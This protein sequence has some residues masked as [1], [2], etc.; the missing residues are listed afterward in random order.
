MAQRFIPIN[1]VFTNQVGI[2]AFRSVGQAGVIPP[3][4]GGGEQYLIGGPNITEAF[5]TNGSISAMDVSY[6][7]NPLSRRT[8]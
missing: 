6:T 4:P 1:F 2:F 7:L 8:V 5:V 3:P